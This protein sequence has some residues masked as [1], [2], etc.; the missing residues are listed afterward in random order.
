M[1]HWNSQYFFQRLAIMKFVTTHS[2]Q[3][4]NVCCKSK[5]MR[6][7]KKR[8]MK[9]SFMFGFCSDSISQCHPVRNSNTRVQFLICTLT[10]QI[11]GRP[12][13]CTRRTHSSCFARA[14]R[15]LVHIFFAWSANHDERLARTEPW[16][17]ASDCNGI[18]FPGFRVHDWYRVNDWPARPLWQLG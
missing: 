8:I 2:K 5:S 15:V 4:E 17:R 14:T 11:M 18:R 7:S 13:R 9:W 1:E 12:R 16:I 6:N 10:L 3:T